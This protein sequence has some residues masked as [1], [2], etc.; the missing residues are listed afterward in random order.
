MRILKEGLQ[1]VLKGDN[2]PKRH[3]SFPGKVCLHL[4]DISA[5]RQLKKAIKTQFPT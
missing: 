5:L 4:R 2:W 1:E 3:L